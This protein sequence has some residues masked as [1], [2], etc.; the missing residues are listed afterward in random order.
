MPSPSDKSFGPLGL[1]LMNL[2]C[3]PVHTPGPTAFE[4]FHT[5]LLLDRYFAQRPSD[6][7]KAVL[8]VKGGIESTTRQP[9]GHP[10]DMRQS[11][12]NVQRILDISVKVSLFECAR[13]DRNVPIESTIATLAEYVHSGKIGGIGQFEA[14]PET[15]CRAHRAHPIAAVEVEASFFSREIFTPSAVK[16]LGDLPAEDIRRHMDR[17]QPEALDHNMPIVRRVEGIAQRKGVTLAQLCLAW[18]RRMDSWQR[19]GKEVVIVPIPGA[20]GVE[21]LRDNQFSISYTHQRSIYQKRPKK[22]TMETAKAYNQSSNDTYK[23]RYVHVHLYSN[24]ATV[25]ASSSKTQERQTKFKNSKS[26]R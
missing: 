22:Q 17:F 24:S 2:T 21:R 16:K 23:C 7:D 6:A 4:L 20:T 14:G 9:R 8:S 19:E 1:G 3:R 13:V 26:S 25:A 5:A 15:I 12:D 10:E 11:V 18:V